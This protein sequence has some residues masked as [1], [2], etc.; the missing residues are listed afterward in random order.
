MSNEPTINWRHWLFGIIAILAVILGTTVAWAYQALLRPVSGRTDPVSVTV[1]AGQSAADIARSLQEQGIIRSALALRGYLRLTGQSFKAG[2]YTVTA[3]GSSVENVEPILDGAVAERQVT[4]PEGLRLTEIAQLLEENQILPAGDLLA[5]ATYNP[6]VVTLPDR[7]NLKADTF[8]EGFFFPETY[9]FAAGAS[10]ADV[11]KRLMTTY[12]E[13]TAELALDYKTLILASIVEREAKFDADRPLI[14]SV[15]R[16]RLALGMP[17][18]AD[19]TVQYAAANRRYACAEDG[20]GC[21]T[22]SSDKSEVWW[23]PPAADDLAIDSPYNTYRNAG[24][25]PRPICNPGLKSI[26]AATHPAETDYLYFVTDTEGHAHFAI[27]L[28]EHNQNVAQYLK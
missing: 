8:L 21:A 7:Y 12:L 2:I 5:A 20:T 9:R 3:T 15:Y 24:L 26:E 6:T 27:T 18:Q 25:P 16:N 13:R 22:R 28:A 19:P 17:L 1:V 11:I 10:A 23:Q 4:I 14:A